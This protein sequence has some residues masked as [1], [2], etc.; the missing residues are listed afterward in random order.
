LPVSFIAA[1]YKRSVS[2]TTHMCATMAFH[3]FPQKSD[4]SLA[5]TALCDKSFQDFPFV[6][7]SPPTIVGL[8]AEVHERLVQVPLPI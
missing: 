2:V 6:I 3:S 5:I 4:G 8:A 7:N 1:R